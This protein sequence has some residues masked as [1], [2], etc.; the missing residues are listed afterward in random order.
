LER[1]EIAELDSPENL[2]KNPDSIFT[3]L[4]NES[5]KSKEE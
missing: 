5:G 1:G 4:Y 2:L 3:K